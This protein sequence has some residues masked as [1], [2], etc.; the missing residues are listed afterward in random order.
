VHVSRLSNGWSRTLTATRSPRFRG[1][2]PCEITCNITTRKQ[3]PAGDLS[4]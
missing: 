1:M 4:G 3:K 2:Y